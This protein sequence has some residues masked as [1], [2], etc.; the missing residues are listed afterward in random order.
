MA[1]RKIIPKRIGAVKIPKRLRKLGDQVLA[2][3][4]ARE[5]AGS[6]LLALGS[7]LLARG[8]R[9]GSVLRDIFEHPG[10]SARA[11]R[12]AGSDA[13]SRAG[14]AVSG[15]ADAVG[16]A[17]SEVFDTLRR[18]FVRKVRPVRPRHA[19]DEH[20]AEEASPD[21]EGSPRPEATDDRMH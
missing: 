3:P 16:Q 4:R 7:A 14:G 20:D 5:M 18:D 2:D 6:A 9:K 8:T 13:A 15:V 21:A 10:A 17:V 19:H 12:D 1:R 11:A